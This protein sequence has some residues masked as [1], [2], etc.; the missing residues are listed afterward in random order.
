LYSIAMFACIGYIAGILLGGLHFGTIVIFL[1]SFIAVTLMRVHKFNIRLVVCIVLLCTGN[2][3]CNSALDKDSI[4]RDYAGEYVYITATVCDIPKENED[5][6]SYTVKAQKFHFKTAE[7]SYECK[8]KITSEDSYKYGDTV[9]FYGVLKPYDENLNK[10]AFDTRLYYNSNDIFYKMYS[11]YSEHLGEDKAFDI[12]RLRNKLYGIITENEKLHIR[13]IISEIYLDFYSD[14][15]SE[16]YDLL[17]S[18]GTMRYLYSSRIHILIIM[19]VIW[20]LKWLVS[21]RKR[22]IATI[23]LL[24]MYCA[25]N[26]TS[27]SA[28]RIVA[29]TVAMIAFVYIRGFNT[30]LDTLSVAVLAVG[31]IN[32]YILATDGFLISAV[33]AVMIHILYEPLIKRII[34]IVKFRPIARVVVLYAILMIVMVPYSAYLGFNLSIYSILLMPVFACII[35]LFW[36]LAP[37]YFI[38]P[39]VVGIVLEGLCGVIIV[40]SL[41]VKLLPFNTVFIPKPTIV[42]LLAWYIGVIAIR[43]KS[44]RRIFLTACTAFSVVFV[45]SQVMR[46]N[47]FEVHFVSVGQGDAAVV[48][49]PYKYNILVD[50][51]GTD[52]ISDYDHGEADFIPY[53]AANGFTQIDAAFVSHY[54][55]DHALGILHAINTFSVDKL[56]LPGEMKDNEIYCQLIDVAE[57][58][59]TQVII[60]NNSDEITIGEITVDVIIAEEKAEELNERSAV[61]KFSY[62]EFDA[63]FT[64][65]IGSE[66][67]SM[68]TQDI[69]CD[70]MKVPHHGSKNSSSTEFI[71]AV[72]PKAVFAGIGKNNVHGFPREETLMR[73]REANIPFFST[74]VSGNIKVIADKNGDFKIY[75]N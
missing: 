21:K 12:G 68:I 41:M 44:A 51:G 20:L 45:V 30:Y 27:G 71:R 24:V 38:F 57:K 64:G 43:F 66:T 49:A 11:A 1:I 3:R 74:A 5:T 25:V 60:V 72:S 70:I 16:L 29:F 9:V 15:D 59:K 22:D 37:L 63:L 32:P 61:Y 46:L 10:Y 33:T 75:K 56:Y 13:D 73:Y 55:E 52:G 26:P 65:D 4:L 14:T 39:S 42:F 50:G 18:S 62:G 48:S 7:F 8:M 6:Y 69:S 54:H 31:L 17:E 28:Y 58:N 36:V 19:A 67:E 23:F 40:I 34:K 35:A 53:L 47:N 2:L